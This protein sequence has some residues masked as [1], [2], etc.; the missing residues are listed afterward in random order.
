M[1]AQAIGDALAA[2]YREIEA[3]AMRDAPICNAALRVEAIGF[4]E[5]D[6]YALGIIV[7]P[8]FI[9]LVA[10][11]T[12]PGAA[13][14]L[15]LLPISLPAGSINFTVTELEGFGRLASCSLFSPLF[16]FPDQETA[17]AVAQ[18]ALDAAF[19][20][21]LNAAKP[22]PHTPLNRRAFLRGARAPQGAAS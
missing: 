10:A 13:L 20:A 1:S 22:A 7:T 17:R 19:D 12:T 5:H 15:G 3:A 18:E 21:G 14:P 11:P 16:E 2:R 8:W 4:R 9:N 6:G